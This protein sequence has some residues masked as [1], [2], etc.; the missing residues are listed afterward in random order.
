MV[1][2]EF[3]AVF[4]DGWA[5]L[6]E[7]SRGEKMRGEEPTRSLLAIACDWETTYL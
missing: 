3:V 2:I 6:L 4:E 7:G 5:E 1:F